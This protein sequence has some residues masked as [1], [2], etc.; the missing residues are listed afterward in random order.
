MFEVITKEK[1]EEWAKHPAKQYVSIPFRGL[2]ES[3]MQ[4]GDLVRLQMYREA[5]VRWSESE[6][7]RAAAYRVQMAEA[8]VVLEK[9]RLQEL[10]NRAVK[11]ERENFAGKYGKNDPQE[12]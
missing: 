3:S 1:Q 6:E 9:A 10:L 12:R 11:E 8:E 2:V 7:A 4:R 5:V